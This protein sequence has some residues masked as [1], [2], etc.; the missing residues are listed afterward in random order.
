VSSGLGEDLKMDFKA[1]CFTWSDLQ[2]IYNL[3]KRSPKQHFY[4]GGCNLKNLTHLKSVWMPIHLKPHTPHIVHLL[5][6]DLSA[7]TWDSWSV[8]LQPCRIS[9]DTIHLHPNRPWPSNKLPAVPI[10]GLN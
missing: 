9:T 7:W 2:P 10:E 3:Q 5:E 6:A 1:K 4:L 8:S